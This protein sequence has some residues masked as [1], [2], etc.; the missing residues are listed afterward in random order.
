MILTFQIWEF[1]NSHI[2]KDVYLCSEETMKV[3]SNT[4]FLFAFS[5][6]SRK[7][8]HSHWVFDNC[9]KLILTSTAFNSGK[10]IFFFKCS[11]LL[12][13][14]CRGLNKKLFLQQAWGWAQ[15]TWV[16]LQHFL[17]PLI[18]EVSWSNQCSLLCQILKFALSGTDTVFL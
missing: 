4:A 6:L 2:F 3:I 14:N 17:N 12:C 13:P 9:W 5:S 16:S 7:H 15:R 1:Q 11:Q 10:N 8:Y 18:F